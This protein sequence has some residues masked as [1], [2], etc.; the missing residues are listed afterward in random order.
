MSQLN[1]PLPRKLKKQDN[2]SKNKKDQHY[3]HWNDILPM[4][5]EKETMFLKTLRD[6][7]QQKCFW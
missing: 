3:S 6:L 4:K 2:M 7:Q 5:Q 1:M